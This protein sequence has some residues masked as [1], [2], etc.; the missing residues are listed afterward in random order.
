[1]IV[2]NN[3]KF[4]NRYYRTLIAQ[5]SLFKNANNSVDDISDSVLSVNIFYK[6]ISFNYN[7]ET[8]SIDAFTIMSSFGGTFG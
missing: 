3:T 4:P 2:W 8:I 5:T 7:E 1:M 6:A